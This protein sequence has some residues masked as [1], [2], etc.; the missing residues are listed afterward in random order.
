[1]YNHETTCCFTGHRP[2]NLP[3][4]SDP[5][6]SR[7]TALRKWIDCQLGE[8]YNN[9]YRHFMCG[10]ALGSDTIFAEQVIAF[11]REHSDVTLFA[12]VPC[13]DQTAKWT[14]SQRLHYASLIEKCDDIRIFSERYNSTCMHTRNRF[15]VDSSSVI[16]ACYSGYP[17]GT[18]KTLHYAQQNDLDIR[19]F[20]PTELK[21]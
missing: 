6:D 13:S 14:K 2:K 12:A 17:G 21:T 5:H 16:L 15:M 3:W 7:L 19:I 9:G 1:M 11:R 8:L 20:D 18:M 10:M 4:G